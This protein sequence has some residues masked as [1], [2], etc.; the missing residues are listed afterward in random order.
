[1]IAKAQ[2]VK[3]RVT[4]PSAFSSLPDT[5]NLQAYEMPFVPSKL[6]QE[7]GTDENKC[8]PKQ[9]YFGRLWLARAANDE[10]P[11]LELW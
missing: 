5:A 3:S 9:W 6:L 8:R 1:M 4:H 11:S 7:K 2:S 10:T